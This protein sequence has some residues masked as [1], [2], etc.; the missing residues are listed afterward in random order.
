AG[1]EDELELPDLDLVAVGEHRVV[2]PLPVDVRAVERPD[3]P[4][5][6]AA[7]V[8]DELRMAT[9]DG[10][11]VEEDV[12]V[13]VAPGRGD[14]ALEDVLRAGVGPAFDDEH[15]EALGQLPDADGEGV[16]GRRFPGR[17][18]R[19]ERD[20]VVLVRLEGGAARR[21]EVRA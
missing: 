14:V 3:V 15:A 10:D 17:L 11:V 9:A 7:A 18:D 16:V 4:D 12:A 1:E 13:R 21:A 6:V 19:L 20:G 5:A 8:T 2:G